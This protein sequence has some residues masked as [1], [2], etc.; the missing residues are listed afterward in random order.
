M[1]AHLGFSTVVLAR[2]AAE[3]HSVDWH[4]GD[5]YAGE[6]DLQAFRTNLRSHG[7]EE[8]VSVHIGRFEDVLPRFIR[9]FDLIFIDGDHSLEAVRRDIGLALPLLAKGG[10]IAFHDYGRKE[11][12]GVTR[13]VDER[14]ETV[15]ILADTLAV[16]RP[17]SSGA[18]A[19]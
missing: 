3:L 8:R 11:T 15:T 19:S 6:G 4:K 18:P 13:A 12:D 16:V 14:F 9:Q 5:E 10:V 17:S 2:A 1:G 7:V